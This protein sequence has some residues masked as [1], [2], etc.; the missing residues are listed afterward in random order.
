MASKVQARRAH[1]NVRTLQGEQRAQIGRQTRCG[2]D[3]Q[4]NKGLLLQPVLHGPA[5]L[6]TVLDKPSSYNIEA[7]LRR[8]L[9][10]PAHCAPS[11]LH[12]CSLRFINPALLLTALHHPCTPAHC[13]SST[14]HSCSLCSIN[15][16]LLLTALHQPCTPALCASSTLHS[17]SLR[18]INPA[19][20][21]TAP[22][23][24]S[25][26]LTALHQPC[27]SPRDTMLAWPL[28][29]PLAM[30]LWQKALNASCLKAESFCMASRRA[31]H[32]GL[33]C[34]MGGHPIQ[35]GRTA[36]SALITK[37]IL[38]M[39]AASALSCP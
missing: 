30:P 4:A 25:L 2:P 17:C 7:L 23:H 37:D 36:A 21:P 16:A 1:M 28:G 29:G 35:M 39:C 24:P 8:L 5:L 38:A 3:C 31:S 27:A 19:L 9:L 20:L 12:S 10:S 6:L 11:T 32:G 34:L 14:L 13:A 15:P 22:H 18:F 26:L 33:I